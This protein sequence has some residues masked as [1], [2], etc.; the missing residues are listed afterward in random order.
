MI[1]FLNFF[2]IG[3]GK[4]HTTVWNSRRYYYYSETAQSSICQH[5]SS[6]FEWK[7]V[8]LQKIYYIEV[9]TQWV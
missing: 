4:V 2:F 6:A 5:E 8:M 1:I 7:E 9:A 3:S